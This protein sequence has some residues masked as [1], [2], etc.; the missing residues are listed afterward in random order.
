MNKKNTYSGD[1][2]YLLLYFLKNQLT[3]MPPPDET[4]RGVEIVVDFWWLWEGVAVERG[5]G[6]HLK[7]SYNA[8][9]ISWGSQ[10]KM[11]SK[12]NRIA[13]LVILNY[14]I[15]LEGGQPPPY[16][17]LPPRAVGTR[18]TPTVFNGRTTF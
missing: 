13:S 7:N 10:A 1:I 17:S 3:L 4:H 11:V 15:F 5:C 14:K 9:K 16:R 8:C 18:W 12:C 2:F 6:R